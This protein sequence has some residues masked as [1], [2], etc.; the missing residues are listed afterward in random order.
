VTYYNPTQEGK[1]QFILATVGLHIKSMDMYLAKCKLLRKKDG[2]CYIA[3]P[4]E[5]YIDPKTGSDKW[6][7]FF[8]FGEKTSEFFQKEALNAITEYCQSKGINPPTFFEQSLSQS[9]SEP[10]TS[11]GEYGHSPMPDYSTQQVEEQVPF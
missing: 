7:N 4:S 11:M 8:W 9:V 1:N 5:K 2:G 6:S 10:V 3:P